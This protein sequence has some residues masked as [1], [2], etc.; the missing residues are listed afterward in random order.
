MSLSDEIDRLYQ[1]PLSEFTASRNA[2][3][4]QVA[5]GA[6]RAQVR[7]LQKPSLPAWAVNQLYW[8]RRKVFDRLVAAAERLRAAHR[9][10]LSGTRA[11][12]AG[13]ES[14]HQQAVKAAVEEIRGLLQ[15]AGEA[16]S[17]ATLAA[18]TE[19]LQTLPAAGEP[20]R[21]T[22]PL[23]PMGFE[24]L[25]GLVPGAGAAIARFTRPRVVEPESPRQADRKPDT[26]AAKRQAAA[27]RQQAEARRR[28][29]AVEEKALRE[30]ATAEREA[31]AA[32]S[33]S[34]MSLARVRRQR[35]ELETRLDELTVER[36]RLAGEVDRHR[37]ESERAAFERQRLE[38][39]L[40]SLRT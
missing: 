27:L 14:A 19:T 2:L 39:R 31:R 28:E 22:K 5:A 1:L 9:Q 25:A 33:R 26:G 17:P 23:K 7:E 37:K 34:E 13:A 3:L 18:A 6:E 16:E 30:A 21:L 10:Q 8:R 4:K 32:L 24:A 20:G 35:K 36:D 40:K 15:D 29:I 11:D 12:V 38:D